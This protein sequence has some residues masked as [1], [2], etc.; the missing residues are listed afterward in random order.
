MKNLIH[1]C[2][3]ALAITFLATAC[4]EETSPLAH[5]GLTD[6][7]ARQYVTAYTQ[8]MIHE[9]DP[10]EFRF[11][12]TQDFDPDQ[13]KKAITISPA[14]EYTIQLDSLK[15]GFKLL[16]SGKLKRGQSYELE[17]QLSKLISA[18][19]ADKLVSRFKVFQQFI[20][21][22]REGLLIDETGKSYVQL[23]VTTSI[24][25][26]LS[27]IAALFSYPKNKVVVD[28]ISPTEYT[29]Q[30]DFNPANGTTHVDWSGE[31]I[32]A[33][34]KGTI[35]VWNYDQ[36]KFDVINTYFDRTTNEY[37][38]YFTKILDPKQ[39]GTGLVRLGKE[40]AEYQIDNNVITVFIKS[41]ANEDVDL[42]LH[43]GIKAKDGSTL[44]FDLQYE[45]EVAVVKPE[46]EWLANGTYI[47][48]S[49]KF[50]LPFRAKALRSVVVSIVGIRSE[51]ASRYAAWNNMSGMDQMEMIRFGNLI[52]KTT[53]RLDS[54]TSNNLEEWN[55]FGLDFTRTFQREKGTIYHIMLSFGPENTVLKCEN[56]G[57]YDFVKQTIDESWFENR[58]RH[59]RYRRYYDYKERD[60]PCDISY[61]MSHSN[62]ATNIHCTNVFPIIKKGEREVHVSVKE[63]LESRIAAGAKVDLISLQGLDIASST[64]SANGIC[65]FTDLRRQPHAIRISHDKEVSYFN[66]KAGYENPLTEFD[67]SSNVR[68]VDN[69]VF[70]YTERAVWRPS[71][72][73]YLDLMLNRAKFHFEEGQ[74]IV[75][76]LKNPK[77]VLYKKYVRP[78]KNGQSIY[79]FK[80]PTHLEAPTG[81]WTASIEVGPLRKSKTLRVETIKPNVVDLEYHFTGE[82]EGWIYNDQVN[83]DVEVNYLAGYAMRNGTVN[84]SANIM[85]VY[86]PFGKFKDYVF[87]PLSR[88]KPVRDVQLWKVSTD[89][90]G[91]SKFSFSN[92]FKQYKGVSKIAIDTK[93]DLPGGGLNTET[94]SKLV[95]PFTSYVGIQKS[96]GRGWRGSYRYGETPRIEVI[97]ISQRGEELKEDTTVEI[98]LYK[99]T[100]DWWYDRYRLTRNHRS[101][102]SWRYEKVWAKT[103]DLKNGKGI[104]T[105]DTEANESGMYMLRVKDPTSGHVSE[106]RFHSVVT[107]DYAVQSNP[108]FIDLQLE[109][110]HYKANETV[111]L[112]LPQMGDAKAPHQHRTRRA[113]TTALLARPLQRPR[114]DARTR[115][116]VSQCLHPRQHCAKLRPTRQRPPDADVH[117]QKNQGR[118]TSK[119]HRTPGQSRRKDRTQ[120]NIYNGGVRT[121]RTTHGIHRSPGR[122]GPAQPHRDSLHPTR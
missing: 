48:A 32:G 83:G 51:N 97:R 101:H 9:G 34:E 99:Y 92:D 94:E 41:K 43:R 106:Y 4:K 3:L 12:E 90:E 85:P 55:E 104:Y 76:R 28:N 31:S 45:V 121:Q 110:E 15:R 67:I 18:K 68:D 14:F 105:H 61:Y 8:G 33:I 87:H 62:I 29:V 40:D 84:A 63:L 58:H 122:Q 86:T 7:A 10:I 37:K 59:Y 102:S 119:T 44:P 118:T 114:A 82:S 56:A 54:L 74:P 38:I 108:M 78:V 89:Q 27:K 36:D 117:G 13:I 39:D 81:Y 80:M 1:Y 57:L 64:V 22:Q 21:V 66:V 30:L 79:T 50:K 100:N 103:L 60:N 91:K 75:V 109:K 11:V 98:E 26:N 120:Q 35:E 72:T 70:V 96:K 19:R 49:G 52:H 69:R 112:K 47:P 115:R 42:H 46:V 20:S 24:A 6:Q 113:G 2:A 25:E 111:E 73:I 53:Y 65:S 5:D 77:N 71:D 16:P 116:L 93:I 17:L 88:P 23:L 107:A 95:S